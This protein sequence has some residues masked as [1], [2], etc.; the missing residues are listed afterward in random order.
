MSETFHVGDLLTVTTDRL[1]SPTH[2]DGL[3]RLVGYMTGVP[4]FTHQLP[5]GC[6]A[7][8]PSLLRQHPWLADVVVPEDFSTEESV[9]TWLANVASEH[10]EFHQVEPLPPEAYI[11]QNPIV[12]LADK[13]EP[14]RVI[15]VLHEDQDRDWHVDG[16]RHELG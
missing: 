3:Y 10:G 7:C 16:K 12:E 13:L 5:R 6:D 1:V 4:H 8:K 15:P 14:G 9:M 2:M 11:A